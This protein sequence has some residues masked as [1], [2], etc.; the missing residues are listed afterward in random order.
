MLRNPFLIDNPLLP[1][2]QEAYPN[3]IYEIEARSITPVGDKTVADK[4]VVNVEIHISVYPNAEKAFEFKHDPIYYVLRG[5]PHDDKLLCRALYESELQ[6]QH[7]KEILD[8]TALKD[9][10]VVE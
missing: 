8:G 4:T 10:L 9:F 5:L 1:V 6:K 3:N 7:P 2:F